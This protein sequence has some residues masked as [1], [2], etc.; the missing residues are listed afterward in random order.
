MTVDWILVVRKRGQSGNPKP[1]SA[2]ILNLHFMKT[3]AN[4]IRNSEAPGEQ[5]VGE[6][7]A[8]IGPFL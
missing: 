3:I 6:Q 1:Q 7:L 5:S 8:V 4:S 2:A